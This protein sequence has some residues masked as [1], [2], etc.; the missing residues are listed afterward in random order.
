MVKR[1]ATKIDVKH[2]VKTIFGADVASVKTML[3]PKKTRLIRGNRLWAK[4]PV[5]KK[6]IVTLKGKATID[7][8]K[9]GSMKTKKK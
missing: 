5:F 9:I 4:R 7:P 2:A 6:A 1:D 3:M 8:N